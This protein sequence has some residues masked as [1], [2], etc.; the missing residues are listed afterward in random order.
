MKRSTLSKL[1]CLLLVAVLAVAQIPMLASAADNTTSSLTW[2][3]FVKNYAA[4]NCSAVDHGGFLT[5]EWLYG[6]F[7]NKTLKPFTATNAAKDELYSDGATNF[8]GAANALQAWQ[9]KASL[10]AETVLKITAKQN[11]KLTLADPDTIDSVWCTGSRYL[12]VCENAAGEQ[13]QIKEM[14]VT[15]TPISSADSTCV[16]H[17]AAG[18]TLYVIYGKTEDG[19]TA[20]M[21]NNYFA[22]MS[23]DT[24][25][26]DATQNPFYTEPVEQTTASMTFD[27]LVKAVAQHNN[28]PVDHQGFFEFHWVYGSLADK[29][30]LKPFGGSNGNDQLFSEAGGSWDACGN[31]LKAWQW[32][33]SLENDTI[34]RI[35]A[36]K[37]IQ[38]TLA[39]PDGVGNTWCT[40]SY[41]RFVYENAEGQQKLVKEMYLNDTDISTADSTCLVHLAAGDTLYVVYGKTA[42]GST[43]AMIAEYFANVT[44]DSAAYDAAQRPVIEQT[45]EEN[46]NTGDAVVVYAF[47]GCLS[48]L[49]A[50]AMLLNR[51]KAF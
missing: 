45:P 8:G 16:V 14:K 51:K 28:E 37:D 3:F 6:S 44:A 35:T 15:G 48:L 27:W 31:A 49:A 39:D 12:F 23:L 38:L 5:Y 1:T 33:A 7:A 20:G 32:K 36:K 13:K 50:A 11:M 19:T 46:P 2:D 10:E 25:A 40:G 26:Y 4:N 21:V 43:E 41:Y 30:N 22:N 47:V 18:D 24:A 34:L 42:D 29:A 17:L 9:W